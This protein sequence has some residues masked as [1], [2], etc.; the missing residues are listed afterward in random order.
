[1]GG[2]HEEKAKLDAGME[3]RDEALRQI[4]EGYRK[5]VL[6]RYL[7]EHPGR[8]PIWAKAAAKPWFEAV[9]DDWSSRYQAAALERDQFRQAAERLLE[10]LAAD[11]AIELSDEW[12]EIGRSSGSSYHT[13]GFGANRYARNAAEAIA[14]KARFHGVEA[15]VRETG[16]GRWAG[17][18]LADFSVVA[19][20][21]RHGADVLEYRPE[22]DLRETVRL[23]WKRGT[24]PRV[25]Y[26]FLPHGYE[27]KVGIDYF[28]N[29]LR[30]ADAPEEPT[31]AL[32]M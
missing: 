25:Y 20:V 21:T 15:E 19:K 32:S 14:D 9:K 2:F 12:M 7:A 28:G 22:P 6:D 16:R 26:P 31:P 18:E 13:Q 3:S 17:V 24:N 11:A 1:M 4:Q 5:A 27:E 23:C 29:D 8:K 10:S 30:A